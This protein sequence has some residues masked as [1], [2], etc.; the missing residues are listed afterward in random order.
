MPNLARQASKSSF[1]VPGTRGSGSEGQA[2]RSEARPSDAGGSSFCARAPRMH[3]R[4]VPAVPGLKR[5]CQSSLGSV[6][7]H[8]RRLVSASIVPRL[9]RGR[10]SA[11]WCSA[12]HGRGGAHAACAR[13]GGLAG[14]A[15]AGRRRGGATSEESLWI[16]KTVRPSSLTFISMSF[17]VAEFFEPVAHGSTLE[18]TRRRSELVQ[19]G[20]DDVPGPAAQPLG[21]ALRAPHRH[22][23]LTVPANPPVPR[24]RGRIPRVQPHFVF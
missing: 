21:T 24:P 4:A 12:A 19:S 22:Q 14:V 2:A 11:D 3:F 16:S 23:G 20:T 1:P 7:P 13:G 18:E 10:M 9:V 8:N 6:I 17:C 5:C 15:F